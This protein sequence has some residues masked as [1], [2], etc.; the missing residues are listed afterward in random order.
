MTRALGVVGPAP[1]KARDVVDRLHAAFNARHVDHWSGL[2]HDEVEIACESWT[3]RGREAARSYALR[4]VQIRPGVVSTARRVVAESDDTVVSEF[5]LVSSDAAATVDSGDYEQS[6][7]PWRLDGMVCQIVTL[8]DDRVISMRSYYAAAETDRTAEAPAPA[9]TEA[10]RGTIGPAAPYLLATRRDVQ[11][12]TTTDRWTDEQAALHRVAELV[13]AG[14]AQSTVFDAVALEAHRLLGGHFTALL[15]YEQ[16]GPAVVMAMHGSAGLDHVL[17]VGM[18]LSVEGDGV[19]QRVRHAGRAVRLDSYQGVPGSNAATARELNLTSGVGAPVITEGRVWGAITVLSG[20]RSLP[21]GAESRL[22]MFAEVV[23]TAIANVESRTELQGLAHEQAALREVAELAAQEAPA[24]DVLHAVTVQASALAGVDFTT[25]LRYDGDGSTEIVAVF[26]APPGIAVGMRA[27]CIGDG[28]V[29]QVWRTGR[30]AR[31]DLASVSG[32]GARTA[33]EP[34]F[35]ASAAVP[36]VIQGRRW[37]TL[38]AVSREAALPGNIDEPLTRFAELAG[39]AIAAAQA[40][41]EFRVLA[42]EQTALR[43]VAELVAH[44]ESLEAV[45]TAV[46]AE[47]SALLDDL[48]AALLR[49]DGD[50]VAVA[51]AVCNSPAPLGLRVPIRAGTG[52]ADVRETGKPVRVD[53]F[54]GT[55]LAGTARELGVVA[56]VAVPVTVEGRVW[57]TLSTSSSGPPIPAGTEDRLT[58]FAELAAAAIA[59]AQNKAKLT[60][61]RARV[62]ATADETRRRIQRDVH[63]S[64]QQRL[65]HTIVAL[66]LARDALRTGREAV[67]FVEEALLN[68]ERASSELRDVVRGILPA[69]LTRGGLR[70][71]LESLVADIGL[72][73]HVRVT[74]PRLPAHTETTAYFVVAEALTN[75]V[76]HARA[77]RALVDVTLEAD[78]L[79]IVVRDDGIGGADPDQGTGLTGLLDRVEAAEGRLTVTSPAGHGT[80]LHAALPLHRPPPG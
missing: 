12:P 77:T 54:E 11:A 23:A 70:T 53:T 48:P 33:H 22:G 60:A 75:V 66:K 26:G 73:I 69:A 49:Y 21:P 57:G 55:A 38:V 52:T 76:K 58:Q 15:R 29:E 9:C 64:V 8:R 34:G 67:Q 68:A 51:V 63:D 1:A 5:R 17:H 36:I 47:A 13:A 59:N 46:T 30:A 56:A 40:R 27:P 6:G 16:D 19:V 74:A 45:F 65:V 42:E 62:V 32:A 31:V 28:A 80:T 61:S 3:L 7:A 35:T 72:P 41:K 50:D 10:R 18:R 39:T 79:A 37:G 43:R 24:D 44:G 4:A 78:V 71:G 25:L 14:T 2:L 20:A